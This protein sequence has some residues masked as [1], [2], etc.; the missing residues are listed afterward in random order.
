MS[1]KR[2]GLNRITP[3]KNLGDVS[4]V[5]GHKQMQLSQRNR[6]TLLIIWKLFKH[7]STNCKLYL[8]FPIKQ[9][10]TTAHGHL[11]R[12]PCSF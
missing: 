5:S 1:Q 4:D 12:A 9:T 11:V 7:K 10:N 6:A 2:C 3:I 8:C